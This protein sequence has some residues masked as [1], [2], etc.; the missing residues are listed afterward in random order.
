MPL[1]TKRPRGWLLNWKYCG[2]SSWTPFIDN[3]LWRATWVGGPNIWDSAWFC[4]FDPRFAPCGVPAL[5]LNRDLTVASGPK[6]ARRCS[7]GKKARLSASAFLL[8]VETRRWITQGIVNRRSPFRPQY[9][10]STC[11]T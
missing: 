11:P 2:G 4:S 6:R 3:A 1:N 5:H 9:S 7:N 8:A 10:G